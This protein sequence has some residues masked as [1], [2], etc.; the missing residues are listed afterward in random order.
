M[1]KV[2]YFLI[3]MFSLV[4]TSTSCEKDDPIVPTQTLEQMYPDWANLTWISTN[5]STNSYPKLDISI[6]DDVIL[7]TETLQLPAPYFEDMPTYYRYSG[8][9]ITATTVTFTKP[10]LNSETRVY[11]ILVQPDENKVM[12]SYK[13]NTYLLTKN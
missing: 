13:G 6:S 10:N 12:L 11:Q 4:L 7:L 5:G 1:K 9:E 2:T 3:L 8:L